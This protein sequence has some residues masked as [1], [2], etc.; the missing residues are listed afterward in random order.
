VS[1]P[2][3][4]LGDEAWAA[5][6]QAVP[7]ACVDLLPFRPAGPGT[8]EVGLVRRATP[9]GPDPRWCH[10]GG[11]IRYGETL[12]DALLRHLHETVDGATVEL[13]PDPQ[14]AYVMQ[15]F[16]TPTDR[17]GD[18]VA[19]GWDPRRHAVA[20]CFAVTMAGDPVPVPGGEALEFGW[21]TIEDVAAMGERL[22]P[23]TADLVARLAGALHPA[24]R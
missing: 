7:I 5:V 17:A 21:F 2:A 8:S 3:T 20:L 10:M 18:G 23:G 16:A 19:Y 22:W 24:A 11:R 15:W 13:P 4:W 9:F 14:P 12:R 1:R 6:Q